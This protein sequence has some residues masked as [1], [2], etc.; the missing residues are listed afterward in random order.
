VRRRARRHA[1]HSGQRRLSAPPVPSA[2]PGKKAIGT[3]SVRA[4]YA[5]YFA[6]VGLFSP[7]LSLWFDSR[8][9][10]IGEIAVLLSLPQ[11]LRIFAPP[12]WGWLADRGGH[13]VALLRISAVAALLVRA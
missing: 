12:F 11:V 1:G 2:P 5:A 10:S 13:R 8:G 7:Y 6:F 9:L 3:G 4:L